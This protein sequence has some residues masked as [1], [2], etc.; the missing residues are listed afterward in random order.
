MSALPQ[1]TEIAGHEHEVRKM[2]VRKV[3]PLIVYGKTTLRLSVQC[4]LETELR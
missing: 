2:P 3:Q 4:P 1:P